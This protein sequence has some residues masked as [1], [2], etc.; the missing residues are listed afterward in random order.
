M[1]NGKPHKP[2]PDPGQ[3]DVHSFTSARGKGDLN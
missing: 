3:R 2:S 1:S